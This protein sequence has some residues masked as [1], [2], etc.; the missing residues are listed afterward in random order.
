[1]VYSRLVLHQP[2][3]SVPSP[4][5]TAPGT[6]QVGEGLENSWGLEEEEE[7][8]EEETMELEEGH[9]EKGRGNYLLKFCFPWVSETD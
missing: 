7:E 2:W 3:D 6:G 4:V 5:L 1:M 9:K 8:E